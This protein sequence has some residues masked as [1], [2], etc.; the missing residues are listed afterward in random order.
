MTTLKKPIKKL[1]IRGAVWTI[2]GYG[3]SQIVRFIGNII[4]TKLLVPEF[5]GLMAVVNT[6]LMGIELFSDLGIGQS[7]IQNKR[8]EDPEFFNTA[9]TLQIGRGFLVW[10]ICLLISYPAARFYQEPRLLWLVPIM[11]LM[12]I[13]LGFASP[14][15]AILNRRMAIDKVIIFDFIVQILSLSSLIILAWWFRSLWAFAIGG[16]M[17]GTIR[18]VGS[19]FLIPETRPRFAWDKTA[20][21]EL[22]SFG[23]WMFVATALMFLAEQSD[24]LILGRLLSFKIVGVY[25]IAATLANMPREVI[26]NLGYRVIFPTI[27]NQVDLPRESLRAKILRQ[28]QLIVFV[29]AVMLALL[30]NT[31]DLVIAQVYDQRYAEA[32]WM[33]PILCCGIWFSILFHTTSPALLAL[34]KP[35]YSAQ[36]NL[37]RFLMIGIGMPLAFSLQG[38]LGVIIIIALSDFPLYLAN[39]YG[40][41]CEKLFSL[42]QDIQATALFVGMVVLFAIIR[43]SIGLGNPFQIFL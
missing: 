3:A 24:R 13:I 22:L 40:L 15:P 25:T 41:W 5:F 35:V 34:G 7:I 33:M 2:V 23:R 26:K 18:T 6:L 38:T 21:K 14:A 8:G 27:S 29:C 16:L 43:N 10:L 20:L 30:V 32:R 31:G 19:Y 1:A 28:R 37:L 12:S 42:I 9:W 4:L 39:L 17:G 36:S 11:G